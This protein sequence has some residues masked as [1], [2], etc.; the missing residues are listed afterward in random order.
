[1]KKILVFVLLL[2][3]VDVFAQKLTEF[4]ADP[5]EFVSALRSAAESGKKE[6]IITAANDFGAL[7]EAGTLSGDQ[8]AKVQ[9]L[10][11]L[12]LEKRY[13]MSPHIGDYMSSLNAMSAKGLIAK[14]DEWHDIVV[15]LVEGNPRGN[16]NKYG[17]FLDF[18]NNYFGESK[19]Y[20]KQTKSYVVEAKDFSMKQ[21][22]EGIRVSFSEC[23]LLGRTAKDSL[24]IRQTAGEYDPLEFAWKGKGGKID[25][26]RN[27]L[28]PLDVYCE[29]GTY[30]FSMKT[31][32]Y[33]SE[34]ALFYYK[35]LFD[36]AIKGSL[37]DK[38]SAPSGGV[39][40]YPQFTSDDMSIKMDKMIEQVVF[41]GGF[42]I[43][44]LKILAVGNPAKPAKMS[45]YNLDNKLMLNGYSSTISIDD[46]KE[47]NSSRTRASLYFDQD[48]L[49]HPNL[50]LY[51]D[52]E[53]KKLRLVRGEKG[54]AQ[55]S[56]IDS[57]H[58]IEMDVDGFYWDLNQPVVDFKQLSKGT[59]R[60]VRVESANYYNEDVVT[61][62]LITSNYNPIQKLAAWYESTLESDVAAEDFARYIKPTYT[63]ESIRTVIVDLVQDG[64]ILY[65]PE[66]NVI[67]ILPK[68]INYTNSK[69]GI[70]DY[71]NIRLISLTKKENAQLDLEN[72]DLLVTGVEKVL[73]SDSQNVVFFPNG[74][75]LRI[76]KNRNMQVDGA[77]SAGMID[78]HGRDLFFNYDE[79]SVALDSARTMQL[80]S[81]PIDPK[82]RFESGGK[83]LPLRTLIEDITGKLYIDRPD[84]K[85]G[86]TDNPNYPI[87]DATG[88]SFI[89]YD[90]KSLHNGAYGREDFY[91]RL[92]PFKL[93][94]VDKLEPEQFVFPGVMH[95]GNIFPDLP[96]TSTLQED[97]TLGFDDELTGDNTPIYGGLGVFNGSVDLSIAK[98]LRGNG[99]IDF[100]TAKI[101]SQDYFFFPDSTVTVTD[102]IYIAEGKQGGASFPEVR[103]GAIRA[104]WL[105]YSDS[106][107]LDMRESEFAMF[108]D[109][110][111]FKGDLL[112]A[113]T[114]L[115]GDGVS[116]FDEA[117]VSSEKFLFES[118]YYRADTANFQIRSGKELAIRAT[119]VE[120]GVSVS[121]KKA[122]FMVHNDTT[123]VLLPLSKFSSN[124]G[125]IFWD[126]NEKMVTLKAHEEGGLQTFV[127]T[128]KSQKG[129]SFD[130]EVA[131]VDCND[132]SIGIEG[133]SMIFVGDSGI[134]PEGNVLS[135]ESDAKISRLENATIVT[136]IETKQHT[137]TEASVDIKSS[138]DF[139]ATGN[140]NYTSEVLGTQ[141]IPMDSIYV[142]DLVQD[143]KTRAANLKAKQQ[144]DKAAAKAAKEEK[145]KKS[146]EEKMTA[147]E[148]LEREAAKEQERLNT[149]G[150]TAVGEQMMEDAEQE[151]ESSTEEKEE[152]QKKG[153][154]K[155]GKKDKKGEEEPAEAEDSSE[156]A[157]EPE[158]AIAGEEASEE[159]GDDKKRRRGRKDKSE[160]ATFEAYTYG[161]G[162]LPEDAPLRLDESLN[163]KGKVRLD[164][165][166]PQ[167]TFKGYAKVD[168][169]N[170]R[171]DPDWFS[172]EDD[173][174]PNKIKIVIDNPLNEKKDSLQVAIS[175]DPEEM[176]MTTYFLNPRP[177]NEVIQIFETSG[178]LDYRGDDK[179]YHVGDSDKLN[180]ESYTGNV[181][182]VYDSEKLITA[183]GSMTLGRD[184]G[185]LDLQSAGTMR[186]NLANNRYYLDDM[187]LTFDF[188]FDDKIFEKI[189]EEIK[190][191]AVEGEDLDFTEAGFLPAV[192]EVVG[193]KDAQKLG[194]KIKNEGYYSK[195]KNFEPRIALSHLDMVWDTLNQ[196]F[197]SQGKFGLLSIGETSIGTEIDGFIEFGARESG[198]FFHLYLELENVETSGK[199]WYYFYYKNNTDIKT[200]AKNG[201]LHFISSNVFANEDIAKLNP[202]KRIKIEGKDA[203]RTFEYTVASMFKKTNFVSRMLE[204]RDAEQREQ[205]GE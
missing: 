132:G 114:G 159:E 47:V 6:K 154:G 128:K 161:A 127:S 24:I 107:L 198:D 190:N 199:E 185:M 59:L 90:A 4:P 204:E 92:E 188:M 157:E 45:F 205:R 183:E 153:K 93:E 148:L 201:I 180:G 32:E 100:I 2:A 10:F 187:C 43:R 166:D 113:S 195:P 16:F 149:E 9:S 77:L 51:F 171:I 58:Q 144:A 64:F 103:N 40:R 22:E 1:M 178:Q 94:M 142:R 73:L 97:Y 42:E 192:V 163:F 65:D 13:R 131:K 165:K 138:Q 74:R 112:L 164:S 168:L 96:Q 99:L 196:S 173:I 12:M 110:V 82:E 84:N 52:G 126:G 68:A 26:S 200:K 55:A 83:V 75:M 181:M 143:A 191:L 70:V 202:K 80:Y 34:G 11:N 66:T 111:K 170:G 50:N 134:I 156:E 102:S 135:I 151:S 29:L 87:M 117:E 125:K 141:M 41:T 48:S 44:G 98:G 184:W 69:Q 30:D 179:S 186:H 57:Y 61:K 38:F 37:T 109:K 123:K 33:Q 31:G 118:Q 175:Y 162:T 79:F 95:Y 145:K 46:M 71:D 25:W 88:N 14:F 115:L 62:Y 20:A 15:Q 53:T 116:F 121:G 72:N 89:Y 176:E 18:S 182:S 130:A 104:T 152:K 60:P 86:L 122:E 155:K 63:I 124:S 139:F 39:Y 172:F 3:A 67:T 91:F 81:P 19:I 177:D 8:L 78:F 147:K 150:E 7:I 56:F 129:L 108:K 194:D 140:Y 28:D 169:Q 101:Y 133:L 158:E 17:H 197:R 23:D 21:S 76:Q 189:A 120:A 136:D 106:L 146:K 137:I 193:K 54:S 203:A 36:N 160:N 174:D 119:D 5:S 105:P 35:S 49:Y 167:L 85:S 27:G